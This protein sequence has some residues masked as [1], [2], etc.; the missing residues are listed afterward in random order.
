MWYCHR[1]TKKVVNGFL[2][3]SRRVGPEGNLEY[4]KAAFEK[5]HNEFHR[6]FV[7]SWKHMP[8]KPLLLE[9]SKPPSMILN[10][11]YLMLEAPFM[12]LNPKGFD[13]PVLREFFRWA[14]T[15]TW[16][17]VSGLSTVSRTPVTCASTVI[18]VRKSALVPSTSLVS[19]V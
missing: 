8:F 19:T 7:N 5:V 15:R 6:C 12:V 4:S 11:P 17:S 10:L 3:W 9:P 2:R 13:S 16:Y 1:P 18:S 14:T